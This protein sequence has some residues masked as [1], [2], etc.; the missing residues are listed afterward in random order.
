[1]RNGAEI[2]KYV[3]L[4]RWGGRAAARLPFAG[5]AIV[6]ACLQV[7]LAGMPRSYRLPATAHEYA[8]FQNSEHLAVTLAGR[9]GNPRVS[10]VPPLWPLL[11]L[12]LLGWSD[13]LSALQ[14]MKR[15]AEL[16][17]E[18]EVHRGLAIVAYLFP[19]LQGWLAAF[20]LRIPLWERTLAVPLAARKLALL[21][22]TDLSGFSA[23]AA[24]SSSKSSEEAVQPIRWRVTGGSRR[25]TSHVRSNLKNQDAL[26]YWVS[27]DAATV[28]VAVADGHGSALCFRSDVGSHV[29]VETAVELLGQFANTVE[30]GEPASAIENRARAVLAEE[31]TRSWSAA[32]HRHLEATPFTQAEWTSLAALEGWQGQE[33]IERHPELAYGST[34]LAVLATKR[35]VL[36]M[37]LGNGDILFVDSQGHTRKA[38][39]K[40]HRRAV[41]QTASL[42]RNAAAEIRVH[43]QDAS[44]DLP[45]MIL[46]A[47]DGYANSYQSDDELLKI[48]PEYLRTVHAEGF[49]GI[50]KRLGNFLDVAS[51]GLRGDD[52]TIGLI[53]R[54]EP[55][56]MPDLNAIELE[57]DSSPPRKLNAVVRHLVRDLGNVLGFAATLR[58][59]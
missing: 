5:G 40:D 32:V 58:E 38:F 20:P 24:V 15:A 25:G 18:D 27:G 23:L 9:V 6:E 42:W 35:Y 13:T 53:S 57:T 41:K 34:I 28:V 59:P 36:C 45:L 26:E 50:E 49:D 21:E 47:T 37:Q 22:K 39:P 54:L 17:T 2:L 52:I 46:A 56:E 31:L 43:V 44:E 48:G 51:L 19:E 16:G 7:E 33:R 30:I 4:I 29:A 10:P 8:V 11:A 3:N 12:L 1:M 14:V 55:Q